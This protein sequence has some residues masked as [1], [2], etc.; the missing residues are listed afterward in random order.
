M[1]IIMKLKYIVHLKKEELYVITA[2]EA[3]VSDD[4]ILFLAECGKVLGFVKQVD[5]EFMGYS[6][7]VES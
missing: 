6:Y 3:K 5:V 4:N 2:H 1:D 7:E